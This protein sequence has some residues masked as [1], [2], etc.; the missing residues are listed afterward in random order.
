MRRRSGL[1]PRAG[2][3]PSARRTPWQATKRQPHDATNQPLPCDRRYEECMTDQASGPASPGE[4]ER[5]LRAAVALICVAS[6]VVS[7]LVPPI[8]F[9]VL[10]ALVVALL[11]AWRF[12]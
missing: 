7:A 10:A 12:R 8:R 3:Q 2:T 5:R 6:I 11:A 1:T 4:P 9:A